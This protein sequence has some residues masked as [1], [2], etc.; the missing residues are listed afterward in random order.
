MIPSRDISNNAFSSQHQNRIFLYF[1]LIFAILLAIL[2]IPMAGLYYDTVST[3]ITFAPLFAIL[4]MAIVAYYQGKKYP[5]Y[6]F[7]I[8]KYYL[9][10]TLKF[11]VAIFIFYVFYSPG[12]FSGPILALFR[13]FQ[14]LLTLEGIFFL[15]S[16]ILTIVISLSAAF[17]VVRTYQ[18]TKG[19]YVGSIPE[20]TR[21]TLYVLF[22]L[23]FFV[24]A[25][26]AAAY[27]SAYKPLT[28]T[29]GD[30]LYTLSSGTVKM[31]KGGNP[32]DYAKIESLKNFTSRLSSSI[33]KTS[34]N[35]SESSEEFK[36]N[37]SLAKDDLTASI[38]Q[39]SQDLTD[40]IKGDLTGK[41]DTVGGTLEGSLI[42]KGEDA[43]LTVEGITTTRDIIPDD[44]L[45]YNLGKSG[46]SWNEL[47]IH[48][49]IGSSPVFVGSGSSA[50]GLAGDGDL[51]V[52]GSLEV[53]GKL[54]ANGYAFPAA[55]GEADQVIQ[56]D[57]SGNLVWADAA[58]L[59]GTAGQIQ[60]STGSALGADANLFWDNSAKRLG[61]G[62]GSPGAELEVSGTVMATAFMLPGGIYL[63]SDSVSTNY[64]AE[65]SGDIYRETGNVGLGNN[66]PN[67]RLDITGR[68]RL[69]QGSA[70]ADTAD[71]LYNVSGDLFWN[72][73]KM[74]ENFWTK[75]DT[76][77]VGFN[78]SG[79]VGIGTTTPGTKLD[80]AGTV[81]A[82][83]FFDATNSA[84]LVPGSVN[85]NYWGESGGNIYR[86]TGNVGIGTTSPGTALDVRSSAQV[87][88]NFQ[89]SGA[90][91]SLIDITNTT[92]GK[93]AGFRFNTTGSTDW[94]VGV[95]GTN[96]NFA[97]GLGLNIISLLNQK[98]VIS[99]TGNVGIGT[100]T[101]TEFLQISGGNIL[102]DNNQFLKIKDSTGAVKNVIGMTTGNNI[103][104]G[105]SSGG[106]VQ[107][108]TTGSARMQAIKS[109][110][111]IAD[112]FNIRN[113]VAAGNNNG[114]AID[115]TLNR[116]TSG[117]TDVARI[118]GL[119]TDITDGAYK[120]ALAF[121]T[122][123]NAAPA[124]VMRIDN[125]GNVG[126]GIASP[127]A[128][129][130]V[131]G[132]GTTTGNAFEVADSGGN[133]KF[134]ILDNGNLGSY[135]ASQ[136]FQGPDG[137]YPGWSIK[138]FSDTNWHG[139]FQ[140]PMRYRGTAASPTAVVSGDSVFSN[141]LWG[142]D[143]ATSIRGAQF[144][145][146][147]DAAVSTGIVPMNFRFTTMNSAGVYAER[148]R[149][150]NAGNV[151]IGTIAPV[152]GLQI[153]KPYVDISGMN[154]I[155]SAG[156]NLVISTTDAQAVDKGGTII[157]GGRSRTDMTVNAA[158]AGI[159]GGKASS[160]DAAVLGYMSFY[161]NGG[162]AS[163]YLAEKMRIDNAGNVGIGT[164]APN[165]SLQIQRD[166]QANLLLVDNTAVDNS[167]QAN[168][169]F[170]GS[171]GGYFSTIPTAQIKFLRTSSGADGA[172][173][174]STRNTNGT[175]FNE[176]LRITED[177]SVGIGTSSPGQALDV[178]GSINASVGLAT[179]G[180]SPYSNGVNAGSYKI[181]GSSLAT[182]A[183]NNLKI[184]NSAGITSLSL[185]S[186]TI[187]RLT[188]ATGG[189]VGIGSISPTEK[190][191][192]AGGNMRVWSDSE[193]GSE[194]VTSWTNY[195][196]SPYET[197]TVSG[198]DI[199][200]AVNTTTVGNCYGTGGFLPRAG[201]LFKATFTITNNAGTMPNFRVA[202]NAPLTTY[203]LNRALTDGLNTIYF[204][205][206]D[207]VR[208]YAGFYTLTGVA[209]DF[210][211]SGFSVKQV[212]G[213]NIISN[214]QFTGGGVNGLK[215]DTDGNVGIGQTSPAAPLDILNSSATNGLALLGN[216]TLQQATGNEVAYQLN[217]TTNKATSGNDTGLVINQTDTASPGTS[218]LIEAFV[219]GVS[220]LSVR[221]NGTI[222]VTGNIGL[223]GSLLNNTQTV[224][225]AP[226][227]IGSA[228]STSTSGNVIAVRI[229]PTYNQASGTAANTDLLIN[230]TETA[231][232][233]GAQYLIDAQ[234]GGASR[235]SVD[236][237]G[238]LTA[239]NGLTITGSR[240]AG[241]IG[242]SFA[243]SFIQT[244]TSQSVQG[245][246]ITNT[247]NQPSATSVANTDLL[248]NRIETNLGTTPGAQL[249][250]DA[251]V[252]GASKFNVIN[253]GGIRVG[254]SIR[255]ITGNNPLT[256]GDADFTSA[257]KFGISIANGVYTMT[258]G[259]N[260]AVSITPTYNQTSGTAA[261]TDLLI[262]RTETALGSGA[263]LLIDAQVGGVS[264][265]SVNNG[266]IITASSANLS[267][268]NAAALNSTLTL[269]NSNISSANVFAITAATGTYSQTSGTNGALAIT[270]TYN[271][272]SGTA[273]NTD[274]LIN[275]TQTA[276]GSGTQLLIDAQVGG[277]TMFNISNVG[278]GYL[279]AA[280]WTYGSDRR[281]K[282][283]ITEL[284]YGLDALMQL[285]P[286][287]F[288]YIK[289]QKDQLGFIAQDVQAVI[290]ELVKNLP[291]GLLGLQTEGL[292]PVI[293]NSI[294]EQQAA[295][296]EI[297]NFEFLISNQI[298][299]IN[300]QISQISLKTDSNVDTLQE[301]QDSID[302]QLGVVEIGIKNQE[303]RIEDL[304][305]GIKNQA[306]SIDSRLT[307][308]E[309]LIAI[310][311]TQILELQTKLNTETNLAQIDLNT[312]DAQ[313]IKLL[314]GTDRVKNPED[315]DILGKLSSKT[316]ATGGIEITLIDKEAPT[317]GTAVIEAGKTS[318]EVKTKAAKT[319]IQVFVTPKK[320]L[321][322][323]IGVAKIT[324][325]ESFEA[326]LSKP[327]TEDVG[328]SW[329]IISSN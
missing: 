70:P 68:I 272:T 98:L 135:A 298:P 125:S 76:N 61:I 122:S 13:Y 129:L 202:S 128:K 77:N 242:N 95:D 193:L 28:D 265:F 260:G 267:T 321:E 59:A 138:S 131:H 17:I 144:S 94:G 169:N 162:S 85:G 285:D 123:N 154:N 174:F 327:E 257:N 261:N 29:L 278:A 233:S 210:S 143:G 165:E 315:V 36:T 40:K 308:S 268:V 34:R 4:V 179:G 145:V 304:E 314:L 105:T 14:T 84:Y 306:S 240:A 235:F 47:Y 192:V 141:D 194:L 73:L 236:N 310:L 173:A 205:A 43:D 23:C 273:A 322:Q 163:G 75:Y 45:A 323:S 211:V 44:T 247:Y 329:W 99:N 300:D 7:I 12:L 22:I 51:V 10:F 302:Q 134:R 224:S 234:V 18:K 217:Y 183:N 201:N 307:A 41:L 101:P 64:W 152:G 319:G 167:T 228:Q 15:L 148:M 288:D 221:N 27:P 286:M 245:M 214:G 91:V 293:V 100:A 103:Q 269:K 266:G 107:M 63:N 262:N 88:A 215:I 96:G 198:T 189:N 79:N 58:I 137:S 6:Q 127:G 171:T 297:S 301:L 116:T 275:R 318:V 222:I 31:F 292:I 176:R 259:A 136:I 90:G 56:T 65:S 182:W 117:M 35:I 130:D 303:S 1:T 156:S 106:S 213:G 195:V 289:G 21:K 161:T 74:G 147:V 5:D 172:I 254:G 149:I 55:D 227:N 244:G 231:L 124:E 108:T 8:R 140:N 53:Q 291:N 218:N 178:V 225:T 276:V 281:M 157:L 203:I 311:Q 237:A 168:I 208:Y 243:T 112:V 207:S 248:I 11:L 255:H 102:L 328:F 93:D 39:S 82:A 274:L 317:I 20:L 249:L 316:L 109:L 204:Y 69:A 81:S 271:Q 33:S 280:S 250:I 153:D 229:A 181:N 110:A 3:L 326:E 37:L 150:S 185:F 32:E 241:L 50:Q 206:P 232:G 294:Q 49:L 219:G 184:G 80:V 60:F 62:T 251:Q 155:G 158:F 48:R 119:I 220:K 83:N 287:K 26:S 67:E 264:K 159:K 295:I 320:G 296:A 16:Y 199:T 186:D 290:P 46:K 175:L 126:I 270:P 132:T 263:Q 71:R 188:I 97:I 180:L 299:N 223:V 86:E 120:G 312:Q 197:F 87:I 226:V 164:T 209:A 24:F 212:I 216:T 57:G 19:T 133:V 239:K 114:A 151:G 258:S 230:R 54:Y 9:V 246:S 284:N 89:T 142:Y 25:S 38:T 200:S 309:N 277:T 279:A 78:L 282:E 104:I 238:G 115:F 2:K 113:N 187:E 190:L 177:G 92:S 118:A 166:G 324:D 42:I 253:T 256:I 170:W 139:F 313:F 325:G 191:E 196:N 146:G 160:T 305:S 111:G 52:S 252:G 72:G 30:T 66:S 283:N 121:Y